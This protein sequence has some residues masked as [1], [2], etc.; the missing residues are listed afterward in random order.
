MEVLV[1]VLVMVVAGLGLLGA[2]ESAFQ[3]R[4][5]SERSSLAIEHLK[6]MME[7]IKATPFNQLT[8][9]FP[10]GAVNG[11]IGAGAEKYGAIIGGY[12]LTNEQI[13]VTHQPS[14]NADPRELVVQV[15]WTT[16]G[17]TYQKRM[18]TLR[19]SKAS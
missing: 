15:S 16:G 13:T 7:Q 12:S 3:L 8:T 18:T 2:Y 9:N 11:I 6:G 1:A 17:R 19:S 14:T 10:S 5:T 4:E